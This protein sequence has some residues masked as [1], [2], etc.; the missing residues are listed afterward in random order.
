[1]RRTRPC[2][3]FSLV[4]F[5]FGFFKWSKES[6][7]CVHRWARHVQVKSGD[8]LV[9]VPQR[10]APGAKHS[11]ARQA[12]EADNSSAFQP[13]GAGKPAEPLMQAIRTLLPSDNFH[14]NIWGRR[15]CY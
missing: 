9:T 6:T 1:M 14:Q 12:E 8:L 10:A 4:V 7:Q 13:A 11:R 15:S 3:L 5:R 2:T